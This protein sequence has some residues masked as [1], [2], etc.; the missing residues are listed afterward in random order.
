MKKRRSA[1]STSHSDS[2]EPRTS[3]S[4]VRTPTFQ[5]WRLWVLAACLGVPLLAFGVAGT[6]WLYERHWLGWT[7]L[8]FLCGEALLLMLFRRW[9][10]KEGALLPQPPQALPGEFAPRD[11]AAWELVKES[12]A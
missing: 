6:L 12:L 8:V 2:G 10:G 9:S 7:G 3:E 11:E 4:R 1:S 5:K